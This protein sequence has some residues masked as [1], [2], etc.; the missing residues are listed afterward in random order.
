MRDQSDIARAEKPEQ[1]L[2]IGAGQMAIDYAKVLK[3]LNVTPLVL[4]RGAASAS[5]FEAATGIRAGS[6]PLEQ[7]LEALRAGGPLPGQAIVAVN[8][9]NLAEV[10]RLLFR[11][12]I[13]RLLIEKPAALDL[14]EMAGLLQEMRA[15]GAAA[16]VAYN[17]RFLAS[18]AA[19]DRIIAGDGGALSVFFNFSEPAHRIAALGKPGRELK[20]WF[21]GNSTHVVDLAFYFAG[22]PEWL[23]GA[24]AG[25]SLIDPEAGIFVGHG[26]SRS[27]CHLAWHA[28]WVGPGRWGVEVV[29]KSHR[30]IFQPL[31]KLRL[32]SHASF[33]ESELALDEAEDLAFKPGLLAQ[34]RAFL[35]APD[36]PRLLSLEDHA[37]VMQAMEAMRRG[38]SWDVAGSFAGSM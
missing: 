27:G 1:I 23:Q 36:D 22:P 9:R 4:G 5:G 24:V 32:Q 18:V 26:K 7:Q 25:G 16:V 21:Y 13:R 17:R 31:E 33:A 14:D 35:T 38:E 34:T 28:N 10:S 20:T 11:Y 12:G 29:T 37:A 3:A 6:G 8:A 30:L 2:L 19:A 15:S